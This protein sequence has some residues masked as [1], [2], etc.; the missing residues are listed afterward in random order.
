MHDNIEDRREHRIH[1]A[2]D[3]CDLEA[4]GTKADFAR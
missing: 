3:D 1:N 2:L 4:L